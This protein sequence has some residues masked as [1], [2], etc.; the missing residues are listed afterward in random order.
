[1][2]PRAARAFVWKQPPNLASEPYPC[3]S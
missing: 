1:L 3:Y 2:G